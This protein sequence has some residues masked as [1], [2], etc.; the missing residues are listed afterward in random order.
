MHVCDAHTYEVYIVYSIFLDNRH[1]RVYVYGRERLLKNVLLGQFFINTSTKKL[2]VYLKDGREGIVLFA[3]WA[4]DIP[5][6]RK[7]NRNH[8]QKAKHIYFLLFG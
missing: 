4:S 3:R 6:L 8:R 2:K 7:V 1:V 5:P